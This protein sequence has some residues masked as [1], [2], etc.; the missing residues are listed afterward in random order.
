MHDLILLSDFCFLSYYPGVTPDG[1]EKKKTR[2]AL[3]QTS[4]SFQAKKTLSSPER[5]RIILKCFCVINIV[6]NVNKSKIR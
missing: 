1:G 6:A 3:P 4:Q 2:A 5:F